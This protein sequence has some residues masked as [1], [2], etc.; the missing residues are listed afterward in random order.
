MYKKNILVFIWRKKFQR[1]QKKVKQIGKT[2]LQPNRS[3]KFSPNVMPAEF[4]KLFDG[5][6][7]FCDTPTIFALQFSYRS[8]SHLYPFT[9]FV[10]FT[11]FYN[12]LNGQVFGTKK[13][14]FPFSFR[15]HK[16]FARFIYSRA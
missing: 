12:Q 15:R 6:Q 4:G 3:S 11:G 8:H 9:F 14:S 5:I 16:L 10:A 13:V 7:F 2:W 1:T